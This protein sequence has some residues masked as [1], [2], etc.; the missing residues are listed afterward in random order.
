LIETELVGPIT[1]EVRRERS[2]ILALRR[3]GL[4]EDVAPTAVFL[5][6]DGSNYYSG[7]TLSP[8]GGDVML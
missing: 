1:D 3:L 8:N 5:A 7:Q 2:A 6:S 4:P